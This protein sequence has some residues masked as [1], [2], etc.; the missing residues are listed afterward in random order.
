MKKKKTYSFITETAPE[1]EIMMSG[2]FGQPLDMRFSSSQGQMAVTLDTESIIRLQAFLNDYLEDSEETE[3]GSKFFQP[4]GRAL[5]LMDGETLDIQR[6]F[7]CKDFREGVDMENP[8]YGAIIDALSE[9][10]GKNLPNKPI[11]ILFDTFDGSIGRPKLRRIIRACIAFQVDFV[12]TG[13]FAKCRRMVLEDI[14]AFTN[15]DLTQVSRATKSVLILTEKQSYSLNSNDMSL[16]VPSLFDEGLERKNGQICSRKEVL[17]TIRDL[18]A[19]EDPRKPLT[20]EQ[21]QEALNMK[22]YIFSRR[23]VAKY[24]EEF[25]DIRNSHIRRVK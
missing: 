9:I 25:L 23:T 7:M 16:T 10:D 1:T 6:V 4:T 13:D 2:R 17:V 5:A 8:S 18:I 20:D 22:G 14:E 15:I 24:R 21:I 19:G 12:K 3:E 11:F